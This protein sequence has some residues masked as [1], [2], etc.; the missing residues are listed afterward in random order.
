MLELNR[1]AHVLLCIPLA[2][3]VT[4]C[5]LAATISRPGAP[6]IEGRIVES[7]EN[8][9]YVETKQGVTPIDRASISDIDHPGN[10]AAVIGAVVSAYGAANIAVGVPQCSDQ[11]PAFCVGVFAPAAIGVPVMLWGLGAWA[12]SKSAETPGM[13]H[14][15]PRV[16]VV[17]SASIDKKNTFVGVSVAVTY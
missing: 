6:T 7:D 16:S 2:A 10:V 11:G 17:P 4:G 9:I 8:M 14:E 1:S 13:K 5:G 12:M 15:R 3:L